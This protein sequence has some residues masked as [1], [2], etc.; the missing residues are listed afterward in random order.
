MSSTTL[1]S[2]VQPIGA[3]KAKLCSDDSAEET[4][5]SLS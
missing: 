4:E 1:T 2:K 5:V 3:A